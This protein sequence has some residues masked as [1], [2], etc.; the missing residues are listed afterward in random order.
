MSKVNGEKK[1]RTEEIIKTRKQYA[2]KK[3]R[4][5]ERKGNRKMYYI[6][7]NALN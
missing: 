7:K 4:E 1:E 2:Q 3:Q 5:R 6:K